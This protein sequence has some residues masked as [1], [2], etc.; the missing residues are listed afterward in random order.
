MNRIKYIASFDIDANKAENCVNA[1]Y[2][3]NKRD[4]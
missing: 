2:L 3:S 4:M 1:L